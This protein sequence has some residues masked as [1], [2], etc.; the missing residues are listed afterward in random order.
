MPDSPKLISRGRYAIHE[1]PG[2]DGVIS[3]RPDGAEEDSHQVIP[4]KFWAV[5]LKII[6]GQDPG[7]TPG[8]LM[9]LIIDAMAVNSG[10]FVYSG[11]PAF[12]NLVGA[13]TGDGVQTDPYGNTYAGILDIGGYFTVNDVGDVFQFNGFGAQVSYLS[14]TDAVFILYENTG[15]DVQGGVAFAIASEPYTDAFLNTVYPGISMAPQAP[16]TVT[17]YGML[18]VGDGTGGSSAGA[19]YYFSPDGTTTKLA[20][21]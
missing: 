17:T 19:L 5:A 6:S 13:I 1:A 12:G 9:K 11:P 14:G 16:P 3:Y 15:S 8:K 2:G 18:Y 10:V 21:D 7:L 4:A 20:S